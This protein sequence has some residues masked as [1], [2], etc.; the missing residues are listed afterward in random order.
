[1]N[2]KVTPLVESGLLAAILGLAATYLPVVGLVVE[3]FCPIPIVILTVRQGI[4]FGAAAVVAA[5]LLTLMFIG[6]V[7]AVR[8]TL[9]FSLCGLVLGQCLRKG[10]SAVKC[11]VPTLIMG[12]AAQIVMLIM[13]MAIMGVDLIGENMRIIRESF[14]QSFNFYESMGVDPEVI[15]YSKEMIEPIARLVGLLTPIILFGV[16][17]INTVGSYA[18]TKF[19]F[20]K[21]HMKFAE[22][23]PPFAY[24]RF[25]V[26]FTYLAA[27]SGIGIYWGEKLSEGLLYFISM[28]SLFL[29]LLVGLVQGLS[30][31]SFIADKYNISKLM[32]RIILV[33]LIL[34]FLLVQI[35]AFTGMFDMIF[36]YRKLL[37]KKS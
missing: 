19:I 10:F 14:E 26:A 13:F 36:D 16:A 28:N 11:F 24:W 7:L 6:P 32:R 37:M 31:L 12:F 8:L 34:N 29:A 27:F 15:G 18:L 21:L 20:R 17:L 33:I 2:S 1:M 35:V 9:T 30:L 25:P 3:F 4:K 23:L 22:P 5:F